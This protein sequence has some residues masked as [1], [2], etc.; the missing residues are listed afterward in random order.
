[1][2]YSIK[3]A[4]KK[5]PVSGSITKPPMDIKGLNLVNVPSNNWGR[6]KKHTTMVN[7]ND[8]NFSDSYMNSSDAGTHAKGEKTEDFLSKKPLMVK[9]K[10]SDEKDIKLVN[11]KFSESDD[12]IT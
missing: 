1:M 3:T 2:N 7:L 10:S 9:D 12:G 5:K 11:F 6:K 8:I 4:G